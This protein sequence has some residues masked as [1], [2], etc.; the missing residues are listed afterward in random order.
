M[1]RSIIDC[2][3]IHDGAVQ[4]CGV[5]SKS[6]FPFKNLAASIGRAAIYTPT[7]KSRQT[8]AVMLVPPGMIDLPKYTKPSE[9][10]FN[11]TGLKTT[12]GRNKVSLPLPHAFQYPDANIMV[13]VHVPPAGCRKDGAAYPQVEHNEMENVVV[14][15]FYYVES[16]PMPTADVDQGY[17]GDM[18][19]AV[20]A[21]QCIVTDFKQK[22]WAVL[23]KIRPDNG[24]FAPGSVAAR[25]QPVGGWTTKDGTVL[26]DNAGLDE[27]FFRWYLR[28]QFATV[29]DSALLCSRPGKETGELLY[30]YPA[31]HV[32][33]SQHTGSLLLTLTTYYGCAIRHSENLFV[34][35]G[36]KYSGL[37][38]GEGTSINAAEGDYDEDKDDL[39]PFIT[40]TAPWNTVEL[41]KDTDFIHQARDI[42]KLYPAN[43]FKGA[44]QSLDSKIKRTSDVPVIYY[45][46]TTRL[47]G[48]LK[49]RKAN[50]GGPGVLDHPAN[51]GVLQGYQVYT[52][53]VPTGET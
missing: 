10:N 28:P 29:N 39:L 33:T 12:D 43:Y 1:T 38:G 22:E 40:R 21:S 41:W 26:G 5:I 15:A 19:F 6:Q 50:N 30:A 13:Y 37:V 9:M 35:N 2:G 11:V 17:D 46:G 51:I 44:N 3:T 36:I 8:P 32:S 53:I 47:N 31:A 20:N 49:P 24:A 48:G 42:Y 18:P 7:G 45:R 4:F 23:D 16:Q 52:E 27:H 14:Q 34:L 25:L